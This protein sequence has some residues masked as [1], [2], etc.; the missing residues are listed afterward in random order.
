MHEACVGQQQSR[1]FDGFSCVAIDV[2]TITARL[3][4]FPAMPS[5]GLKS[6]GL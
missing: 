2:H 6:E 1:S 4:H 5:D 3:P